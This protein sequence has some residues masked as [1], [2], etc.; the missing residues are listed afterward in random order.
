MNK[1]SKLGQVAN[2]IFYLTLQVAMAR[3]IVLSQAGCFVYVGFL[4]LLP[5]GQQSLTTLLFTSFVVGLLVD[6]LYNSP[7]LH[8]FASVLMVYNK[9][10]LLNLILPTSGYKAATRLTLLQ[11][12]WKQ[13]TL[14]ALPL[15]VIHHAA[16]FFLDSGT[17]L[18][19][20]VTIR[21]LLSS[22]L[23]TYFAVLVTQI[24]TLLLSKR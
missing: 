19:F 11:L 18:L 8:A 17:S 1:V 3:F 14:L 10:F 6:M 13:Y 7:G 23:L 22:A 15:I 16:L 20:F 12:G 21:K 4:L 5:R 9:S 2:F 24:L